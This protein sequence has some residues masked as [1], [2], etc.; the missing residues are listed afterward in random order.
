MTTKFVMS[1]RDG[2][3]YIIHE[4]DKDFNTRFALTIEE[5]KADKRKIERALDMFVDLSNKGKLNG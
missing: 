4:G 3:Y 5:M 1:N 2:E